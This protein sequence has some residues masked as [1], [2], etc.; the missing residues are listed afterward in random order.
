M[1]SIM[2]ITILSDE[3]EIVSFRKIRNYKWK[4]QYTNA[5]KIMLFL[6]LMRMRKTEELIEELN[7][8]LEMD[9]NLDLKMLK[10][11]GLKMPLL[12]P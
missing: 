7:I 5:E 12:K 6:D 11:I 1:Y 2:N 3:R 10:D 4:K 9:E 8:G